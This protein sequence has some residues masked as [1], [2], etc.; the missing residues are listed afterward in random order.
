MLTPYIE[1][2]GLQGCGNLSEDRVA[3]AF[4]VTKICMAIITAI[5]AFLLA[6]AVV[7]SLMNTLI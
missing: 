4:F 5:L 3:Y 7:Q 1:Y 6:A 2:G